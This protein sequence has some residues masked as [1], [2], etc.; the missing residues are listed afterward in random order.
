MDAMKLD[1]KYFDRVRVKPDENR[2]LREQVPVCEW[3]DCTAPGLYPA[4]KGRGKEG[5]YH[6]FCL[7]HVR[8]YNKT[9]NYFSGMPDE[10]VIKHQKADA[11]GH[12]PTWS[13][14]TRNGARQR[15]APS[16]KRSGGFYHA[17]TANDPFK[18]FR[19]DTEGPEPG[20][21]QRPVG[22]AESMCLRLLNLEA[23]ATKAEIKS[24][25]KELVKRHHPD[26]TGGDKRSEDRLRE[27]I[28][29]YNYLR[30]AGLC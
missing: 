4:P 19:G 28:Q 18:L 16:G 22:R 2:L 5:E 23:G 7:E 13:M 30:Q 24:R 1:S 6:H 17:F 27:V 15:D 14:G 12:R 3:K 25:F 10:D 11:T 26:H 21:P 9:Y 29:A 8:E 20:K